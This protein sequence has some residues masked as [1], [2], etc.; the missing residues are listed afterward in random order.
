MK[1]ILVDLQDEDLYDMHSPL[2]LGERLEN[3][4]VVKSLRTNMTFSYANVDID[5]TDYGFG[6]LFTNKD[7]RRYFTLLNE[8]S[9]SSLDEMLDVKDQEDE[10]GELLHLNRTYIRGNL[11]KVFRQLGKDVDDQT[12][13]IYHFALYTDKN[14]DACRQ[15]GVRSPRIYFMVGQYGIMHLLFFD[16]FHEINP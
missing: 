9:Q 4:D 11:K 8:F 3:E 5:T 14:C 12:T 6:Q 2:D 10:E 13:I 1:D 7:T 16:P 15:T